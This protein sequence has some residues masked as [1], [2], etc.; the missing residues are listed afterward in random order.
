M[1]WIVDF[2]DFCVEVDICI[3]VGMRMFRGVVC[4]LLDVNLIGFDWFKEKGYSWEEFFIV[5]NENEVLVVWYWNVFMMLGVGLVVIGMEVF[6]NCK[7]V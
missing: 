5:I 2:F 4:F 3:V 6:Y 7:K 1:A